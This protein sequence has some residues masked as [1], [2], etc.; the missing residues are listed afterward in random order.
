MTN[1][2]YD[3]NFF[4]ENFNSDYKNVFPALYSTIAWITFLHFIEETL[5]LLYE[6]FSGW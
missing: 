1:Q 6:L 2:S 3:Q 5:F 4:N